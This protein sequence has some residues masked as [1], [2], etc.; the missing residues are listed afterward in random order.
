MTAQRLVALVT[1]AEYD[2]LHEDDRTVIEPLARRG[3]TAVPAV[4][5]DP[6]VDWGRFDLSIIRSTWDYS[7]RR[8]AF[9]AWAASLPAVAN[10]VDVLA[11]NT[12]KRYLADLA[13]FGVPVVETRGSDP[14]TTPI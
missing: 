4:W 11:W 5:D 13:D 12:D 9:L 2:Q 10:P 8:D 6:D 14:V 1:C 7:S 3:I